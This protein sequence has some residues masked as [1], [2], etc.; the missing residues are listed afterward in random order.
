MGSLGGAWLNRIER[1]LTTG[2]N[3]STTVVVDGVLYPEPALGKVIAVD[4]K[5]GAT[6]WKWTTPYGGITRRGAAVAKDLG[7]VCTAAAGNRR[8]ALKERAHLGV[9]AL[10]DHACN[11][12]GGPAG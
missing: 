3:Q 11:G 10:M 6:K 4:G 7:P 8:V 9:D 1:G 2:T 12:T 5:T